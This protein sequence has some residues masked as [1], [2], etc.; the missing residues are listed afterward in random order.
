M[1]S[2]F[3]NRPCLRFGLVMVLVVA[4]GC[5]APAPPTTPTDGDYLFC[6]WN[7]ENFFDNKVNGWHNEPDKDFDR[8]FADNRALFEQKIKNL[9]EVLAAL[10]EGKGPD[11]LALA[12]VET[13]STA[14][15]ALKE[16]LNKALK[17]GT[18]PYRHILMK[19]PHGGRNIA[20]AIITRLPV[21]ADRTQLHGKRLRILE[22][23]IEV[24]GRDLAVLAT[25]W[26]SRVSDKQGEGRD[27]YADAIYGRFRAMHRANA[28]VSLLICGDFNDN[29]DDPSVT[30]NLHA[31]GDLD[32]VKANG[33]PP[34]LYDLFANLWSEKK[35][36]IGSHFYRGKAFLFDQIVV[37]PGMVNG[38]GGWQCL[39]DTAAIVKHRFVVPRGRNK[40][41]PLAFGNEKEKVPLAERGVS[42]HLPVTVRLRV[43]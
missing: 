20:T 25:H 7:T 34:P 30:T 17:P 12:E 37:S 10:N 15:E 8:W 28:D 21:V 35:E 43:R 1:S 5:N 38:R 42:D 9:T 16:S 26:T 31:T 22:G 11:I 40:G 27:K 14:A 41:H 6:F 2:I 33:D 23:H 3:R 36:G 24:D 18:P 19:N 13:E 29:P 4:A 32:R 39:I